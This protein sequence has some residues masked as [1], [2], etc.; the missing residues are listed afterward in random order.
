[1]NDGERRRVARAI[2]LEDGIGADLNE[3]VAQILDETPEE[4][5]DWPYTV[6]RY[7]VKGM[8]ET[9]YVDNI[10]T[11]ATDAINGTGNTLE[12]GDAYDLD[13]DNW[14]E[15]LVFKVVLA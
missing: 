5:D 14:D 3:V 11:Y 6:K 9:V 13:R 7:M 15:R 1:M 8:D 2:A 12:H 4:I 10:L